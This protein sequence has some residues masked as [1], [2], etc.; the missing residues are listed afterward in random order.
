MEEFL[1]QLE[2]LKSSDKGICRENGKEHG[3]YYW[4]LRFRASVLGFRG[5]IVGQDSLHQQERCVS[6]VAV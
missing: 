2:S 6:E 5:S 1:H 4:G 3:N